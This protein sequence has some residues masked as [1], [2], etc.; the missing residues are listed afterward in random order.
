MPATL[1]NTSGIFKF[2]SMKGVQIIARRSEPGL[3]VAIVLLSASTYVTRLGFYSDDWA[4]LGT[5]N[6][7][8]NKSL[9]GLLAS[10]WNFQA[11]LRMR[12]SQILYQ[13]TLFSLFGLHPFGYHIA[14]LLVF[15]FA[16]VLLF[17]T[18][19]EMGVA[20]LHACRSR[21]S[22]RCCPTTPRIGSGWPHSATS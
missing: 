17:A 6:S 4:I 7:S 2:F 19:T 12:P 18:L 16:V 9:F 20:R 1:S 11:E 15:T 10:Q 21:W 13:G 3:L 22:S 14:N 8:D 5:L